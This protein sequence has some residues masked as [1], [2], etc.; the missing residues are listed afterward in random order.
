[1]PEEPRMPEQK[2]SIKLSKMSKGYNWEIKIIPELPGILGK[3]DLKRLHK[4]DEE[5]RKK[6]GEGNESQ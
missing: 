2:E 5:L 1:M 6:Y 4:H 3:E